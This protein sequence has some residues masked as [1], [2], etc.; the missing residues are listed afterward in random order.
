[1]KR[2]RLKIEALIMSTMIAVVLLVPLS[3]YGQGGRTDGFFSNGS[4]GYGNRD[5]G[6]TEVTAG[7]TNDAMGAPLGSGLFIMTSVGVGYV[8]IKKRRRALKTLAILS[9]VVLTT[10]CKKHHEE[11]LPVDNHVNIMLTVSDNSKI[12]VDPTNG[13]V[14][15][16]DGDE[17]IVANDGRYVGKLTYDDG[18]FYGSITE[19]SQDDYLHFYNLG[20]V[21]V[22]G[23][24]EGVSTGCSVSISDQI[25]GLPLISYG[26]SYEKYTDGTAAYEARLYNKCALVK[27][28]VT[29]LST[30]AATCITGMNNKVTVDFSDASF[31]YSI[32]NDGKIALV[33][34]NGERWAIL[35]P[36]GDVAAGNEGSAFSGRYTGNRAAVPEIHADELL[37]NGIDVIMNTLTQPEGALNGLFTINE[38]GKQVVFAKSNLS[39]VKAS[40]EWKFRN[41]QY[42]TVE[43]DQQSIGQNCSALST[44]TTFAWGQTGYNHGAVSYMPYETPTIQDDCFAYGDPMADLSDYSGQ[45]DWGYVEITN[46]GNINKQWRT[47]TIDEW[48]YIFTG[49]PDASEKFGRAIIN[50]KY[51]GVVILPDDWVAPYANCFTGG[52]DVACDDNKY[53]YSQWHQMEDAGAIFMP[54]AGYRFNQGAFGANRFAFYWSSTNY[55]NRRAYVVK[56]TGTLYA[57]RQDYDKITGVPVRLVCE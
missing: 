5:E 27:F 11:V 1:M 15:F 38:D 32:E 4:D 31:D 51:K 52:V 40:R 17:I 12:D 46:G 25:N 22:V 26:H 2:S 30:F 10:Q 34:G 53:T 24:E 39:Y 49:R 47:L 13:A 14:A 57:F 18:M 6:A 9:L 50:N 33:P 44:I 41:N 37:D 35:L 28:N 7:I 8:L 54:Y 42:S 16:V 23:L 55:N 48:N 19:P 45:A 20:N 43:G 56:V 21:P 3:S 29:T 36:Q